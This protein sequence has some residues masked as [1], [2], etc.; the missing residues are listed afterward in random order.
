[1]HAEERRQARVP[2]QVR[3]PG[4]RDRPSVYLRRFRG[5]LDRS[6]L[7]EPRRRTRRRV[8]RSAAGA[9]NGKALSA[10]PGRRDEALRRA[11]LARAHACGG[12]AWLL[13]RYLGL[14]TPRARVTPIFLPRRT[15][16]LF[17]FGTVRGSARSVRKSVLA[18]GAFSPARVESVRRTAQRRVCAA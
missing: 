17:A 7:S 4:R 5:S 2:L 12:A 8:P 6:A 3:V 11:A 1:M 13:R 10:N 16:R 14:S 9:R 15:P 18:R